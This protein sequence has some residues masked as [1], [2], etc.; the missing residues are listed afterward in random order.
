M[1]AHGPL[2]HYSP[3]SGEFA[4]SPP[5]AGRGAHPL[6]GMVGHGGLHLEKQPTAYG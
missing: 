5:E 3:V 1:V 6:R 2:I 4:G